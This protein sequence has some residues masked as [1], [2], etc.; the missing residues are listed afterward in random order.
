M[1]DMALARWCAK[2]LS[3]LC[4]RERVGQPQGA[5]GRGSLSHTQF[6]PIAVQFSSWNL[7]VYSLLYYTGSKV[8]SKVN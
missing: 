3:T 8:F 2:D 7:K 5:G 4:V 6:E 1:R